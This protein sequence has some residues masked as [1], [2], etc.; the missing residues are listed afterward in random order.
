MTGRTVGPVSE[1]RVVDTKGTM[2]CVTCGLAFFLEANHVC[3]RVPPQPKAG[4]VV[5]AWKQPVPIRDPDP[6]VP[7]S[8]FPIDSPQVAEVGISTGAYYSHPRSTTLGVTSLSGSGRIV[9]F[10]NVTEPSSGRY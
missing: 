10:T 6:H 3:V 2:V 9:Y 5:A 8:R 1:D 4:V 7:D